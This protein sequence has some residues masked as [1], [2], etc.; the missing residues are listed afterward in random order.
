MHNN[1]RMAL[2]SALQPSLQTAC[3]LRPKVIKPF[4]A[5]NLDADLVLAGR[6]P[7]LSLRAFA[8][9]SPASE[10]V[11]AILE[12]KEPGGERSFISTYRGVAIDTNNTGREAGKTGLMT[13]R[14]EGDARSPSVLP[15]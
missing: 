15:S 13:M 6:N 3:C 11:K 14:T 1:S 2:R 5:I 9:A 8:T 4:A 10:E 7:A 12:K